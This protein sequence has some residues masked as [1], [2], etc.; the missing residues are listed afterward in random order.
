MFI[1]ATLFFA[2]F[3]LFTTLS[4]Q[5]GHGLLEQQEYEAAREAFE[6]ELR[7]D[8]ASVEAL[9]GMARLYAEDAYAQ[10]NPDTAYTYLREAQRHIRKLSKGRQRRLEKEGLDRSGIRR[11]KNEIRDK[12]LQFAREKGSSEAISE[13]MEHYRRLDHENEKKAMEAF[14]QARFEEL[15]LAGAYVPLRD[16]A[17]SHREDIE[18]YL[19]ELTRPL[20]NAIF[21]TFFRD[22]DSS[23]LEGLFNLLADYPEAAARLDGPLS[24]ALSEKPF[25][26]RAEANLRGLNHRYLPKTIRIIYQYHY[27]TGDWG[28]LLGF[29]NRYPLYSD[30]FNIQAAITIARAAPDLR[31]GF[32]DDR[33]QVYRHYI[34]LAAPVHKAFVALQ[35]MIARDLER[36]DWEKAAATVRRYAPFFGE[37][38]HR[39]NGLLEMLEQPEEGL[40][41]YPIGDA[42]NS[43]LGEYAPSI[44]ADGQRLF[45]C[46][47]MGRNEDIYAAER[48]GETWSTPY[49]ISELNTPENHEAPLAISADKTTLLMYDG[50]IVKYTDKQPE[51]WSAPR[52]FFSGPYT[53]EWQGSTTFASNREAVIFAARSADIIGA[54]NDDNIDLF[55]SL[56]RPDGSWGEPLNLGTT[57]NTPFEDRSPFLHPDMRTLYFSSAGHGGLGSLDVFTAT[58]IGDGWLQWTEPVNLGKEVNRP[59]RDWGYKVSTDGATAYFAMDVPG[60]REEIYQAPIP[61]RFRPEP[62]ST[63]R[64]RI[65]GLDGQPLAAELRLEDLSTGEPAGQIQPD[66]ETGAFFITLPSGRLYSYTVKGPGLY[67]VCNN[68]D[69]RESKTILDTEE[70]ITVPTLDEIQEGDITLPLKNLFFE[71]DKYEIQ[72]ESFPELERLAELVQAYGLTIEVAGHTDHIGGAEYNKTLSRNR[73]EAVRSFLLSQGVPPGQITATGYGL[74]QPVADN[75]TEEG[76]ALNRRVEIRFEGNE[77]MKE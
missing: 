74:A 66:P 41:P 48:T 5:G 1:R 20:Q 29:Q 37:D 26:A 36:K 17:R 23:S 2:L 39:I 63:I 71:T 53:P 35:Q 54:R 8:E 32:T 16:F 22:R 58:R 10:Y 69:L 25:I 70:N 76:R 13:Y 18:E 46:R 24:S 68:I 40:A 56:R 51:G 60:K 72:Q 11:L 7:Q 14:L 30:S 77:G 47:N 59:G 4:A 73:A 21:E 15:Q 44:S 34:E 43:E 33:L 38:D 28:D 9:L 45:F 57:L 42:V 27:I 67:P 65:L 61:K 3:T 31:L 62:V 64:G 75:K 49:P 12:G 19:P 6:K 55:V 52:D 50:G